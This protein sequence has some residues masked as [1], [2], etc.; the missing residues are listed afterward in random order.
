MHWETKTHTKT[1]SQA[2]AQP[3]GSAVSERYWPG[4]A[5]IERMFVFGDSYTTTG[6]NYT[7]SQPNAT[8]PF[9][10][11]AYP[12]CT[13]TNG[14]NWVDFLTTTYNQTLLETVNLA[15]GGATID[16]AL[17]KPYLPTVLSLKQQV[18]DEFLPI[19]VG[20][21][22]FFEWEAEN[23]LFAL[24]FGINDAGNAYSEANSSL[25]L[26]L[27]IQEYAALVDQLYQ[28]GARNF[29]FLN[30]PPV[31]R[32]PLTQ[33]Q[34]SNESS[35]EA[36]ANAAKE[37]IYITAYNFNITVMAANLSNTYRD[38]FAYV[39]DTNAIFSQ[40]LDDPAS[41][42]ETAPYQNT[43][44]YCPP[45]ENGTP[46]WYTFYENCTYAVDEYFWLNSLHPT[47]RMMNVTAQEIASQLSRV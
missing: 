12:G 44:A 13:A 28:A 6:F 27:D 21:P 14:P 16:A 4:W 8:D 1:I 20:H 25:V 24:F 10:N 32:S 41:H 31:D 40:V 37:R 23:T 45:Y 30:A 2:C 42:P 15:Y 46:S 17:V 19:Y 18:Q 11:P 34:G 38:A 35:A 26:T 33:G 3:S 22:A 5:G 36:A 39:F 7:V 9:G 43:T 29:L 47:F